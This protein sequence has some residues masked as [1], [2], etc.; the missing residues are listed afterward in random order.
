MNIL[1]DENKYLLSVVS[2]DV[3]VRPKDLQERGEQ[4]NYLTARGLP[5]NVA[6]ISIHLYLRVH[7]EIKQVIIK[8]TKQNSKI[9]EYSGS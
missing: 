5:K 2:A 4:G 3:S 1:P 6:N 7:Q 8:Y 9:L